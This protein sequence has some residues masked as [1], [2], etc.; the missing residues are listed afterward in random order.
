VA[1]PSTCTCSPSGG[2]RHNGF[3]SRTV[4]RLTPVGEL[5]R[6]LLTELY[7]TGALSAVN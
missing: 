7:R 2:L 3:P 1:V 4:Y 6:P 5:L